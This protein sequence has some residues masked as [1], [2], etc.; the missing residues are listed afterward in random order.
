MIKLPKLLTDAYGSTL[1]T[2]AGTISVRLT[3]K[4]TGK[5]VAIFCDRERQAAIDRALTFASAVEVKTALRK[6]VAENARLKK[7]YGDDTPPLVI[8]EE[9]QAVVQPPPPKPVYSL[10]IQA[11][12]IVAS[13][14]IDIDDIA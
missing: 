3:N 14:N 6:C 1:V 2:G 7:K 10:T 4:K 12:K 8:D 13:K 11:R 9:K 5:C